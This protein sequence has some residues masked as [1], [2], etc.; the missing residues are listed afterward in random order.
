[1]TTGKDQRRG[2]VVTTTPGV[3]SFTQDRRFPTS[4][5]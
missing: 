2:A 1:M 5:S 3:Q 4:C